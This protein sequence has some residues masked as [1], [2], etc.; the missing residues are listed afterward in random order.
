MHRTR[1]KVFGVVAAIAATGLL[2]ACGDN[3]ST[4]TSTPTPTRTTT[5]AQSPA[6]TPPADT[7]VPAPA[8]E[9]PTTTVAPER[10]E[11]VPTE[12]V[13]PPDTSNLSD[14]DKR[15]LAELEKQ[16]I[17]PSSPDIALSI[18]AYV[19]QGTAAGASDQDLMTFVNAMAGSDPAFDPSK[20]PVEKAGQ[21]YISTARAT[22]CQ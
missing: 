1:G 21:I 2:A 6:V 15:F 22:Y 13:P 16:G 3:D 12:A 8:P 7:G 20:M 17:T 5:A 11:P 9:E 10:P 19:C 14:K 4:A 18:G